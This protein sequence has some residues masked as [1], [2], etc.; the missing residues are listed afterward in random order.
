MS[1]IRRIIPMQAMRGGL[2]DI[3]SSEYGG[4]IKFDGT[5]II[6]IK[7]GRK[8]TMMGRSW[9]N[10]FASRFP[11]I[12]EEARRIM[13]NRCVLH[14][15]LTFYRKDNG[16][17]EFVT[18]LATKETKAGYNEVLEVHDVL[19]I[20]G[21][22]LKNESYIVRL[23]VAAKIVPRHLSHI[24]TSTLVMGK[25]AKLR[26]WK[27]AKKQK[28]E[29]IML[30]MIKGR[31]VEG[32]R[33]RDVLKLKRIYTEDSDTADVIVAGVSNGYG[34]R[35]KTFGSLI[36]AMY[37]DNRDLR[38]VGK[39][40]GFSDECQMKLLKKLKAI[41]IAGCPLVG[42]I[43]SDVKFWVRPKVV[44]EIRYHDRRGSQSFRFPAFIRE[45]PDKLPA[46]CKE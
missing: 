28:R 36:L 31:Y 19:Y 29:G 35:E 26:M 16:K 24:R 1:E 46:E 12:V 6:L 22:S 21:I 30:K 3:E 20:D 40:S 5:A 11:R 32:A 15:E 45:R 4:Q 39:T 9:K 34:A 14:G 44:V 13:A 27:E 41:K 18:A 25:D 8:I 33:N 43:P 2:E 10:D 42:R 7:N 37:D 17:E 23:G 38:F